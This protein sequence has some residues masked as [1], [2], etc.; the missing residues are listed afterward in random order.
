MTLPRTTQLNSSES[1]DRLVATAN[2]SCSIFMR[3]PTTAAQCTTRS[4]APG[5]IAARRE[6]QSA[7]CILRRSV[8]SGLCTHSSVGTPET[9]LSTQM[10]SSPQS[11]KYL[12]N[13]LPTKPCEPVTRHL[14]QFSVKRPVQRDCGVIHKARPHGN[15]ACA[16]HRVVHRVLRFWDCGFTV[17]QL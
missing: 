1:M 9:I 10:T 12:T 11:A 5:C 13:L 6:R 17:V 16:V 14:I 3:P 15:R 8:F 7:K 2:V 4:N